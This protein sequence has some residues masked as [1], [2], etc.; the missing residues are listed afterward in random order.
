MAVMSASTGQLGSAFNVFVLL[1]VMLGDCS[2]GTLE[3]TPLL[4]GHAPDI[5]VCPRLVI[6]F[7]TLLL[8]T[9]NIWFTEYI[10]LTFN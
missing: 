6:S 1:P 10:P 3:P 2:P 7:G 4:T 5:P 9:L 8:F